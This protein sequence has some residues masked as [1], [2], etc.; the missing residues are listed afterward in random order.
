VGAKGGDE[1]LV[2]EGGEM[3]RGMGEE[4]DTLCRGEVGIASGGKGSGGKGSGST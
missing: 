2:E 4:C 3:T 1:R